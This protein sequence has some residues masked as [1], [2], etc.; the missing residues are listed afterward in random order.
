[1]VGRGKGFGFTDQGGIREKLAGEPLS[2]GRDRMGRGPVT[3]GRC[4]A[5]YDVREDA[6]SVASCERLRLVASEPSR[7]CLPDG[8]RLWLAELSQS[9][10]DVALPAYQ[11]GR[12]PR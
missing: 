1:M 6:E 12:W 11:D 3:V 8:R 5:E 10:G 4:G 7:C 2:T 9:A